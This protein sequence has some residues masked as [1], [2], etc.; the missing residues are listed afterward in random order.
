MAS[1]LEATNWSVPLEY[2]DDW[3]LQPF[4]VK[5]L[6]LFLIESER[7]QQ[8]LKIDIPQPKVEVLQQEVINT[9][10]KPITITLEEEVSTLSATAKSRK[11]KLASEELKQNRLEQLEKAFNQLSNRLVGH[12]FRSL[13]KFYESLKLRESD[14]LEIMALEQA[15]TTNDDE[16]EF[17]DRI[18]QRTRK[19]RTRHPSKNSKSIAKKKSDK[20][21]C[22]RFNLKVKAQHSLRMHKIAR[23]RQYLS[24]FYSDLVTFE[25]KPDL[26]MKPLPKKRASKRIKAIQEKGHQTM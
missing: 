3:V 21:H 7:E 12:K 8:L 23:L 14:F 1:L 18:L 17:V 26:V 11:K 25:L 15:I 6:S 5:D 10:Q 16:S 19:T 9:D 2:S 4:D 20:V 22:Q 24:N 13:M